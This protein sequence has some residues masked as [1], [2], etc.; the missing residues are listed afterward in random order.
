MQRQADGIGQNTVVLARLEGYL[1]RDRGD[2][3]S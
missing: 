2:D 1:K 3:V